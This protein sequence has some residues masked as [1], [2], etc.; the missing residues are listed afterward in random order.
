MH[1]FFR[2]ERR[3][4]ETAM[5]EADPGQHCPLRL[6]LPGQVR[7]A[8]NSPLGIRGFSMSILSEL[9]IDFCEASDETGEDLL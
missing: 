6:R 3:A 5:R 4:A 1:W 7:N 2:R 9:P 8:G